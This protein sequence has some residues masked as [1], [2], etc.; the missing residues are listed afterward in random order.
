MEISFVK[1]SPTQN[2]TILVTSAVARE[3]Q[4][5]VAARLLEWDSVCGEQVGFL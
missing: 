1:V 5:A 3:A 2:V 4:G